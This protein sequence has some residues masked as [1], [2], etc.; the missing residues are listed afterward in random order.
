MIGAKRVKKCHWTCKHSFPR[1][2]E[3]FIFSL[4]QHDNSAQHGKRI[5]QKGSPS[6][7]EQKHLQLR[8]WTNKGIS[9]TGVSEKATSVPTR[10]ENDE[11]G[12]K[13]VRH[14]ICCLCVLCVFRRQNRL[15]ELPR[16]RL[17]RKCPSKQSCK[18][19]TAKTESM[20]CCCY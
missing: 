13:F 12:R 6:G 16:L 7:S 3:T 15:Q 9:I 5:E 1:H 8:T 2:K 18:N 20:L 17:T 19:L 14:V 11:R 10:N 4:K